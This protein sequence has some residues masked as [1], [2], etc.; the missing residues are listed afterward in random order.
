MLR[1][2]VFSVRHDRNV[3]SLPTSYSALLISIFRCE[4]LV[5]SLTVS[6]ADL[7]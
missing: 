6:D 2:A 3:P 4:C 7:A 5:I 1:A